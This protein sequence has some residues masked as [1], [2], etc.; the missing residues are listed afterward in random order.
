M[1]EER[2][3]FRECLRQGVV[4]AILSEPSELP[5]G[6]RQTKGLLAAGVKILQYR[7]KGLQREQK[8]AELEQIN[9]LP[10]RENIFLLVNDDPVLAQEVKADGVHLGQEDMPPK[11]ARKILGE[12]AIIGL[13]THNPREGNRA[14]SEPVDYLGVGPVFPTQ[15]KEFKQ[16]AG[17][18]YVAWAAGHLPLP[19]VAIGGIDEANCAE[20]ARQGV[21]ACAMIGE[22]AQAADVA[23]KI[24][25]V[26]R[27]L[28]A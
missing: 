15:S 10:G 28:R 6:V 14:L 25:R 7:A 26:E 8:R 24:R 1:R 4:Y 5:D 27:I 21:R 3:K 13:S 23:E 17:L 11:Q 9:A 16:L 19:L 12:G 20:V 18:A 2:K 22:L